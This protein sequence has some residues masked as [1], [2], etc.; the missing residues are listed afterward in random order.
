MNNRRK[1]VIALGASALAAPFG[2]FAQQQGKVWRVGFLTL[3]SGPNEMV[4][5]FRAELQTVGYI[6][7]RNLSIDYPWGAG[8]EE[9]LPELATE[10]VQLKVDVI[11]TR[12]TI[13]TAAVKR[14]TST[15]PIV[16]AASA[17]PVG[18]GLI[19]SLAYPGGNVTGMTRN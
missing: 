5:A 13:V 8:K 11:V 12:I 10:L 16:M 17:D 2:L 15:I 19:A 7:G 9:R 3:D 18:A 1:L 4:D 14:A 6:E